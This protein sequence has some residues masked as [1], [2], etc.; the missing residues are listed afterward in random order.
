M[1][2]RARSL[3]ALTA[4]CGDRSGRVGG[5]TAPS[6]LLLLGHKLLVAAIDVEL[7]SVK[8]KARLRSA[9]DRAQRHT[10]T[11]TKCWQYRVDFNIVLVVCGHKVLQLVLV[12]GRGVSREL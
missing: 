5:R 10:G 6:N 1:A 9:D 11:T 8:K 4:L 7:F 12:V 3:P 2:D